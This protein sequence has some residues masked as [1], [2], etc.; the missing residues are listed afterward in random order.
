MTDR[1]RIIDLIENFTNCEGYCTVS[2]YY[3]EYAENEIVDKRD[4]EICIEISDGYGHEWYSEF[5]T[6]TNYKDSLYEI[7]KSVYNF[8]AGEEAEF[9]AGCKINGK[10]D[11]W[12]LIDIARDI[13]KTAENLSDYLYEY[14]REA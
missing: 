9:I 12:T 1:N 4:T 8:N 6:I 10:P 3:N 11:F 7:H 2:V 14:Y 5:F 13:D